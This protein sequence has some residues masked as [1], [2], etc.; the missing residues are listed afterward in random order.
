MVELSKKENNI[1]LKGNEHKYYGYS[2]IDSES[3]MV[4]LDGQNIKLYWND[5]FIDGKSFDSLISLK[6]YLDNNFIK[7]KTD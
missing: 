2:N 4:D 7:S 1:V 5:T 3:I 6:N